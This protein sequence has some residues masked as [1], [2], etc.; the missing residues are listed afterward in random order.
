[1]KT[2]L[3]RWPHPNTQRVC[4]SVLVSFYD[5]S[6][7]EAIR[8]DNPARQTSRPRRV[9]TSVYRL[10]RAEAAALLQAAVTVR[11]RRAIF[12]AVCAGLRNQELRRLQGRHFRRPGVV[13][14]SEDIAKGARE[15]WVP[16]L[17][18]LEP[19][20]AEI[21][22][23]VVEPG[24]YVLPALRSADPPRNTRQRAIPNRA[25]SSQALRQ[26]V[27][28]VSQ[29]AGIAHHVYPHLLRHAYGDHVARQAGM[30]HAQF[31]LGHATI[32]T[33]E[34]YVRP[35]HIGGTGRLGTRRSV[36]RG[37]RTY[38]LPPRQSARNGR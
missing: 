3:R 20:V 38:V 2:T 22:E 21:V 33:T 10:T 25:S 27:I 16:V 34:T 26:L 29:R 11:E 9:P 7:E 36:L 32:A 14:V 30:R 19:V 28:R 4:R 1:M 17:R 35:A 37:K 5:W 8:K 24:E 12:L 31:L 18:D 23:H 15:R 6:M 13:W